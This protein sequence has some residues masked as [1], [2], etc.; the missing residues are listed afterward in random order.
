MEIDIPEEHVENFTQE[1]TDLTSGAIRIKN[2]Q[3]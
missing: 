1:I 3:E 2:H